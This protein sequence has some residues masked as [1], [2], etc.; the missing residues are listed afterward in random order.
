LIQDLKEKG[1]IDSETSSEWRIWGVDRI[2]IHIQFYD[3]PITLAR[4]R[5]GNYELL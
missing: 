5:G 4:R 3:L 1:I 2:F